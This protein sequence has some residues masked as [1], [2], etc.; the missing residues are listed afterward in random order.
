MDLSAPHR[1]PLT[2][3]T[4]HGGEAIRL[5]AAQEFPEAAAGAGPD[6]DPDELAQ[7]LMASRPAQFILRSQTQD[8]AWGGNLLALA[9]AAR[10]GIKAV[11]TIAEYRRLI[12]MGYP[13]DGRPFKLADRLLFRV[14]SRDEDPALYFEYQKLV[15]VAPQAAQWVRDYEREGATAALAEAGYV[16]DPRIRGSAHRIVTRVS[17]FLRSSLSENP[18]SRSG[19]TTVLRA[20]SYPPSWYSLAMVAALPNLQRERAGFVERL[21]QYL[22][23]PTTRK[24]FTVPVGRR[25]VKPVHLL[26]GDPMGSDVKGQVKDLPLALLFMELMARIGAATMSPLVMRV[27][28]RLEAECDAEG[29][30]RPK[31]LKTAPRAVSPLSYHYYPLHPDSKGPEGR[32]VDVTWRL[33]RLAQLMGRPL[34]YT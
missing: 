29:V 23:K 14:L 18:F 21:G 34:E 10:E 31:A 28:S 33:A 20:E 30:W 26:L 13:R 9:P 32:L 8:G 27:L 25:Q 22:S 5:L 2:W 1:V 3:L 19:P 16:E 17:Q 15:K 24:A 11:G 12:Q 7:A 4:R 6:Q